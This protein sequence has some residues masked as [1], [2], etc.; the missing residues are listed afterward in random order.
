MT[1]LLQFAYF[2]RPRSNT[3]PQVLRQQRRRPS[4]KERSRYS[5]PA[6]RMPRDIWEEIF[7]HCL[8]VSP[9]PDTPCYNRKSP[10]PFI[11]PLLSSCSKCAEHGGRW[12]CRSRICGRPCPSLFATGSIPSSRGILGLATTFRG[13]SLGVDLMPNQRVRGKPGTLG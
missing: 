9:D 10:T 1:S 12:R 2:S 11:S 8:P 4:P 3:Y 5:Y 6:G 7:L 13:S